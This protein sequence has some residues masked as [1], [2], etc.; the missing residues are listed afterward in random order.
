MENVIIEIKHR[1][2]NMDML[3]RES[4]NWEIIKQFSLTGAKWVKRI[5]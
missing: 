4:M 2:S 1:N 5:N 3:K